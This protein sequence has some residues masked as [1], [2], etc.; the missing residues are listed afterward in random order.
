MLRSVAAICSRLLSLIILPAQLPGDVVDLLDDLGN[1]PLRTVRS[2]S[3]GLVLSLFRQLV[4]LRKWHGPPWQL[5]RVVECYQ[6]FVQGNK[7]PSS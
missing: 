1:A 5:Q 2:W 3:P 7:K 4:G 6:M